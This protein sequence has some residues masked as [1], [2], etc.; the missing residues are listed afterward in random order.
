MSDSLAL[1]PHPEI[2]ESWD[3]GPE[4]TDELVAFRVACAYHDGAYMAISRIA[5]RI[6]API[7]YRRSREWIESE[8]ALHEA[9]APD[10]AEVRDFLRYEFN[11][12]LVLAAR[13]ALR[14]ARKPR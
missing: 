7:T 2:F 8:H 1:I 6:L 9:Y 10:Y 14:L 4:V 3:L 5:H 11:V 13:V 12:P